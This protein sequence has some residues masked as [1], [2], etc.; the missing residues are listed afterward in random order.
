MLLHKLADVRQ[1]AHYLILAEPRRIPRSRPVIQIP[2]I[3]QV[4][5]QNRGIVAI[6]ADDV[7][8]LRIIAR[9][10]RVERSEGKVRQVTECDDH[11]QIPLTRHR[12]QHIPRA[13]A[14]SLGM[15][16][17][18]WQVNNGSYHKKRR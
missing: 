15:A 1:P 6:S 11:P 17:S 14:A 12:Q 9:P 2:F 5:R 10:I 16:S 7:G 3:A 18:G 4:P 8:R 13:K